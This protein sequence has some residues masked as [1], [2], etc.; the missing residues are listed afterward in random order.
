MNEIAHAAEMAQQK[1]SNARKVFTEAE[2]DGA[3]DEMAAAINRDYAGKC[4]LVLCVMNGGLIFTSKLVS[5]LTMPIQMDY[6]HATRYENG[7]EGKKLQWLA[8]PKTALVNR[9]V[10]LLDDIFDIGVTL[11]ELKKYCF[12][13]GVS[14]V[15]AALLFQKNHGRCID[16]ELER[17]IGMQVPDEYVFGCGMDYKGF[18]RNLPDVYALDS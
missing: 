16:V 3:I 15:T 17:Y 7:T 10:I 18:F 9:D 11:R 4:P 12:D 13:Q 5:R 2:I 6:I 8:Q 1:L 14:S